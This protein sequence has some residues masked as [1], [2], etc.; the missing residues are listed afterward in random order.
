M[1]W[2]ARGIHAK[3]DVTILSCD[4]NFLFVFNRH[5]P[6]VSSN[7]LLIGIF[8][9][10]RNDKMLISAARAFQA[11]NVSIMRFLDHDFLYHWNF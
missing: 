2:A 1:L 4:R 8:S 5:A 11:G 7:L 6:S 10:G 3:Y 9:M